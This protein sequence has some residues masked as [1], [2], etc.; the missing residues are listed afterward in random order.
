MVL[1]NDYI[2]KVPERRW[3]KFTEMVYGRTWD[4]IRIVL[5]DGKVAVGIFDSSRGMWIYF[6]VDGWGY[7][8][9]IFGN[10]HVASEARHVDF[11]QRLANSTARKVQ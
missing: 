9:R 3:P 8:T 6:E 7:R 5:P 10:P 4:N 1:G 2:E 11:T